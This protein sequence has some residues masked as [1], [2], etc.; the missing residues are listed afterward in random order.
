MNV[1]ESES[2]SVGDLRGRQPAASS[3]EVFLK[4]VSKYVRVA[5]EKK[6]STSFQCQVVYDVLTSCQQCF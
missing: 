4:G 6:I 3:Y 2:E 1:D 5:M